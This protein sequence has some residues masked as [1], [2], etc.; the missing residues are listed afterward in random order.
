MERPKNNLHTFFKKI[1]HFI[2]STSRILNQ[3]HFLWI[4]LT[5]LI[6]TTSFFSLGKSPLKFALECI[7]FIYLNPSHCNL[8]LNLDKWRGFWFL[9][10][11]KKI[12]PHSAKDD[13]VYLGG[14]A[15]R[16]LHGLGLILSTLYA[17]FILTSLITKLI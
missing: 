16:F 4:T 17:P 3:S 8:E 1:H 15:P 6:W 11:I 12:I 10:S 7:L 2:F 5:I 13:L 9:T 14:P